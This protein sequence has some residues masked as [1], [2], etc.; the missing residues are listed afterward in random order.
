MS[1]NVMAIPSITGKLEM[2]GSAYAIDT[3]GAQTT[4]A[5]TAIAINFDRFGANQFVVSAGDGDFASLT[6]GQV[7]DI[8]D[9]QFDNYGTPIAGYALAN[10]PIANFW[11]IAGFSFEL[12]NIVRETGGDPAKDL[13]LS[14]TGVISSSGFKDTAASWSFSGDT[15]GNGLFGWSATSSVP[16]PGMLALLSLGLL[17]IGLRKKTKV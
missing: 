7:G 14:G 10:S 4:D 16:E 6:T 3:S 5:S 15:S 2:T 1:T 8:T 13:L 12:N 9:F 17:G 11:E